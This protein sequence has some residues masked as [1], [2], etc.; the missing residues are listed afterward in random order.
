MNAKKAQH[1]VASAELKAFQDAKAAVEAA[2]EQSNS[3]TATL[4]TARS[5]ACAARRLLDDPP[6]QVQASATLLVRCGMAIAARKVFCYY[7]Q[8]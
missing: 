7:S 2:Q 4:R 3:A 1:A 6:P 8:G 5:E